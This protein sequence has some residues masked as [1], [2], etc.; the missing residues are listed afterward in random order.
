MPKIGRPRRG[1][2]ERAES[3][4]ADVCSGRYTLTEVSK[5]WGI[6]VGTLKSRSSREDWPTPTK[7]M[8]KKDE[9][10]QLAQEAVVQGL[11]G[12]VLNPESPEAKALAGGLAGSAM[13]LNG[14]SSKGFDP[15]EYQAIMAKFAMSLATEGIKT[16]PRPRNL[17]EVALAD[18]L[19]RRALGLDAK[20]GGGS[21]TMIRITQPNG[22][23]VDVATMQGGA[24][25]EYFDEDDED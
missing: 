1:S 14:G 2:V 17:R 22:A 19:A 12:S 5:K 10:M 24:A 11:M 8:A 15:M 16:V 6:S 7:V 9:F 4:K 23:V 21:A 3:I 20:G 25:G 18:T 13:A